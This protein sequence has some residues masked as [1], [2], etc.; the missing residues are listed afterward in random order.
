LSAGIVVVVV[1]DEGDVVLVDPTPVVEVVLPPTEVVVLE[2]GVVVDVVVDV[3]VDVVVVEVVVVVGGG[4]VVGV[5]SKILSTVVPPP[6]LPKRSARGRPAMSSTTVTKR[7]ETTKT[8]NTARATS[9]HRMP[10]DREL[11]GSVGSAGSGGSGGSEGD[12]ISWVTG[13]ADTVGAGPSG[14]AAALVAACSVGAEDSP[15]LDSVTPAASVPPRR[16]NNE[17]SGALTTTCLTALRVRSIDWKASAVPVV[18]AIEPIPTPT[19][20]PFTPKTDATMAASTA[21]T[22]EARIC[23]KENFTSTNLFSDRLRR[24]GALLGPA[25]TSAAPGNPMNVGGRRNPTTRASG[26]PSG[27]ATGEFPCSVVPYII[28][29]VRE[30]WLSGRAI[31]LHLGL[32]SVVSGCGPAGWRRNPAPHAARR[33]K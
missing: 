7:S 21:P 14:A 24:H 18:A 12:A 27:H 29:L 2:E 28:Q 33:Q 16:R 30:G 25:G 22:A 23:R 20:V 3:D 15:G 5:F 17:L 9:G 4:S 1:A 10:P 6:P 32:S 8:P 13:S 31:S 11:P 26:E 19:T